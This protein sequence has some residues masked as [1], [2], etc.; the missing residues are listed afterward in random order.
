M[1][2]DVNLYAVTGHR[3]RSCSFDYAET[4]HCNPAT[5]NSASCPDQNVCLKVVM[6][7]IGEY[8]EG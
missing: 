7:K 4:I 2:M 3:T 5:C 6:L 1:L 8:Y